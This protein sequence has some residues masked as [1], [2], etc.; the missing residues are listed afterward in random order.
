[1][2][3]CFCL[4]VHCEFETIK[5]IWIKCKSKCKCGWIKCKCKCKCS[6][7]RGIKCKCKCKCRICTCICNASTFEHKPGNKWPYTTH[8]NASFFSS[9]RAQVSTIVAQHKIN[10]IFLPSSKYHL[11]GWAY[12]LLVLRRASSIL[13]ARE[14]VDFCPKRVTISVIG[15]HIRL[16]R[17]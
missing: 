5:C 10:R 9:K 17:R 4:C 13:G 6:R 8:I 12:G 11:F 15:R 2:A 7:H 3:N 14:D 16:A 1:M